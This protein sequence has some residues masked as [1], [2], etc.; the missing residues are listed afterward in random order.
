MFSVSIPPICASPTPVEHRLAPR[1]DAA[2][3]VGVSGALE[4]MIHSTIPHASARRLQ[5]AVDAGTVQIEQ[6]YRLRGKDGR[7]RWFFSLMRVD[8]AA[9]GIPK[10]CCSIAST[11]PIGRRRKMRAPNRSD[12]CRQSSITSPAVISLKDMSG[13][14]IL[15]NRE[16]ERMAGVPRDAIVG[17]TTRSLSAV[18]LR[19][20]LRLQARFLLRPDRRWRDRIRQPRRKEIAVGSCRRSRRAGT[21]AIRFELP[22]DEDVPA[23]HVFQRDD[24]RTVIEDCLQASLRFGARIFPPPSDRDVEAIEQHRFGCPRRVIDAHQAE[25]QR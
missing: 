22:I 18:G 10:R 23:G 3:L 15:I 21:P 9:G 4:Q 1:L 17:K 6:E 19:R 20:S 24:G 14:Y 12:A 8:Y 13:R 7:Y 5:A 16:F 2:E 25:E 11:S